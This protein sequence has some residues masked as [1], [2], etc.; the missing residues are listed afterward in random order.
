MCAFAQ[1]KVIV[2]PQINT[3]PDDDH[4]KTRVGELALAQGA[5]LRDLRK[6]KG[7]T[8]DDLAQRSGLHFNTV[9]RI[10]R[11]VSDAS[12]E[13]LY[14]MSLALGVDP[15]ELNPF[16]PAQPPNQLSSGLDD[17]VFVL[18]ELLDVRVSAG[19]GAV[20]T[21]QEHMGR[22]AFSRSWMARKGVKPAHA[23]IVHARGDSMADKI[24]NGDILLV[25]TATKSLDQD[26]VYVIQLDGHDYVKVLQRDFSTGGLQII[27]Y[28]PAYKPQVLSAEQ[29]AELHI[30]GR[31]VWH[32]G[33]I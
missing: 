26:G 23:R 16:Q 31:V 8:I 2:T 13:Q 3:P 22:F 12:L 20:N 11:G 18:V 21:S 30:S 9:G 14:V 10:E 33:E 17:E 28:N 29:A 19:N 1:I 27:S 4:V 25:D 7:L 5:R 32:G 6:Q 24:N 15:S